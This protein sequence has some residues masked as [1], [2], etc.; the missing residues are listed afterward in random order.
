[1]QINNPNLKV[2]YLEFQDRLA[3]VTRYINFVD[4]MDT[5]HIFDEFVILEKEEMILDLQSAS[6]SLTLT[7]TKQAIR[8]I[9][10]K[11]NDADIINRDLLKTLR[12]SSYLLLYNLLEST[13]AET[14]NAIH[15]TIADEQLQITDLSAQLHRIILL[16]LQKGLSEKKINQLS[17]SNQDIRDIVL[18][19]GYDKRKL[20]N[21][22]IDIDVINDFCKRYGFKP[23]PHQDASG[24]K[25]LYDSSVI[26]EIRRKRNSLAHGSESFSQCGQNIVVGSLGEKLKNVEAVLMAVFEGLNKFLEKKK[27]LRN[28][29]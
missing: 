9:H 8:I 5:K 20:F 29:P 12:A 18:T 13:M 6:L 2:A 10:N 22:N 15:T 3:E 24:K 14:I 21:G 11:I 19:L 27:Y 28:P 25:L 26:E 17:Q 7:D 1:M 23:Y 4:N 16:S